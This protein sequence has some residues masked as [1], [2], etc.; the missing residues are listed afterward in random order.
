MVRKRHCWVQNASEDVMKFEFMLQHTALINLIHIYSVFLY[1]V[2]MDNYWN[3][4]WYDMYSFPLYTTGGPYWQLV[5]VS[6]QY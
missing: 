6:M 1:Q 3:V 2:H 5:K 4:Q